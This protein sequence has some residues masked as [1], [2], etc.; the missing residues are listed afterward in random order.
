MTL[1]KEFDSL[2]TEHLDGK[3][4]VHS[5][6]RLEE[7]VQKHPK[8]REEFSGQVQMHRLLQQCCRTAPSAPA[9]PPVKEPWYWR[10]IDRVWGWFR[11]Y[12]CLACRRA[13]RRSRKAQFPVRAGDA[14]SR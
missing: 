2:V 12:D 10:V 11:P 14:R 13:Y 8:L 6:Q 5:T 3:P 1:R 7:I 4:S 9:S